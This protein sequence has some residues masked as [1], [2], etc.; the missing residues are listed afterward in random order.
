MPFSD[1]AQNLT[2]IVLPGTAGSQAVLMTS[3]AS[4]AD[5]VSFRL[6]VPLKN[7][8]DG[9]MLMHFSNFAK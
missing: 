4:F 3:A 9:T 8:G 7:E 5:F 6:F 2:A 1:F